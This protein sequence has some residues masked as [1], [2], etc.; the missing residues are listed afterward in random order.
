VVVSIAAG[1]LAYLAMLR[2]MG[3]PELASLWQAMRSRKSASTP[4]APMG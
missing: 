4:T 3:A 1:A 2:L